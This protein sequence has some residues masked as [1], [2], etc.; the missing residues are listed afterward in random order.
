MDYITRAKLTAEKH[1]EL[2][3]RASAHYREKIEMQL[4]PHLL[5]FAP[6]LVFIS[7][8]FDG[9]CD[10]YYY[11][12]TEDDFAWVTKKIVDCVKN[13]ANVCLFVQKEEKH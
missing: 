5:S 13:T 9:H 12:L 8:G 7:A 10:D 2:C 11:Y 4:L 6:D 3:R 1:A